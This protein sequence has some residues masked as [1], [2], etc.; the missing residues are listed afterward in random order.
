MRVVIAED[1]L[2][3]RRVL[4]T[5]L[6]KWGYEVELAGDGPQA[7]RIL[8]SLNAPQLVILD[9]MMPGKS[10]LQVCR[11]LRKITGRP[12]TYVIVITAKTQ[13]QEIVEG[14]AAGADDYITKPVDAE[15]LN[16]RLRTA[17]RVLEL[18]DEIWSA[19]EAVRY[20]VQATHDP[21]TGVWNRGAVLDLLA[22]ELSRAERERRPVSLILADLDHFK[23]I[24]DGYGHLAGDAVLREATR[25][26]AALMRPYDIVGRYGG[27]EFLV[28]LPGCDLPQAQDIAERIRREIR[29]TPVETEEGAIPVTS[30]LGVSAT[31]LLGELLPD[32]LIQAADAALYRAK[33]QG[34]DRVEVAGTQLQPS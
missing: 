10:G 3:A 28:V 34:R 33:E 24:N 8:Q 5:L 4:E 23:R 11:E 29:A 16:A 15:D 6:V 9:W 27:E 31:S 20:R 1:D 26:M 18:Q 7:W 21:L 22:R 2:V 13:H 17:R 30:S 25:R 12:Y 14:L 19:R 32:A